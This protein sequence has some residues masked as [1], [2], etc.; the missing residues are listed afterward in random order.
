MEAC[1][2]LVSGSAV[3]LAESRTLGKKSLNLLASHSL[4]L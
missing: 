4:Y 3:P 1:I 2:G